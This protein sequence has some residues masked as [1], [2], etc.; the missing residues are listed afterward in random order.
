MPQ[1]FFSKEAQVTAIAA[2]A[3]QSKRPPG[4]KGTTMVAKSYKA[5]DSDDEE[6]HYLVNMHIQSRK[7]TILATRKR[8]SPHDYE[9]IL[10]TGANGSLFKNP[11]LVTE[12]HREDR[13]SFDRI[14]GVLSTDMV[15][16]FSGMSKVHLHKDAIANILSFSQLRRLGHPNTYDEGEHPVANT[17]T[18]PG[19]QRRRPLRT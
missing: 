14:S 8:N 10:D 3:E 9:I 4:K 1:C 6:R 13:V 11:S 16:D 5:P 2:A 7:A 17:I 15:C 19:G 18:S 12:M